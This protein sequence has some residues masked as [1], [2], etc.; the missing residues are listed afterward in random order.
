MGIKAIR[1]LTR[2]GLAALVVVTSAC[3]ATPTPGAAGIYQPLPTYVAPNAPAWLTP[4]FQDA[5]KRAVIMTRSE[6][7]Q[8]QMV[9]VGRDGKVTLRSQEEKQF[10]SLYQIVANK[11]NPNGMPRNMAN[12]TTDWST[13]TYIVQH[14]HDFVS[15]LANHVID[16]NNQ[17]DKTLAVII[18]YY[19]GTNSIPFPADGSCDVADAHTHITDTDQPSGPDVDFANSTPGSDGYISFDRAT[20]QFVLRDVIT[21]EVIWKGSLTPE[22]MD[23]VKQAESQFANGVPKFSVVNGKIQVQNANRVFRMVQVGVMKLNGYDF[24]QYKFEDV[25]PNQTQFD[26]SDISHC[27]SDYRALVAIND[28]GIAISGSPKHDG[29]LGVWTDGGLFDPDTMQDHGYAFSPWRRLTSYQFNR[30]RPTPA[31]SRW[32]SGRLQMERAA[33]QVSGYD[34]WSGAS[35]EKKP[36]LPKFA[37]RRPVTR[38]REA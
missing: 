7:G 5:V 8:E 14:S 3:S 31:V 10:Y 1:N 21:R 19:L 34:W 4:E 36:A 26:P 2:F 6:G 15:Q 12:Y 16:Q 11:P 28:A 24:P 13:F 32:I 20:G 23:Q 18:K 9:C 29:T 35:I 25:D 27:A 37:R 33:M 22:E 17:D 38:V 30:K